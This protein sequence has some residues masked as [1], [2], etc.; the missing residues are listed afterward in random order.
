MLINIILK[1]FRFELNLVD[2]LF[3]YDKFPGLQAILQDM[4]NLNFR[5]ISFAPN[6]ISGRIGGF[7]PDFEVIFFQDKVW[8][9][10]D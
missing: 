8:N 7:Y 2:Y 9:Y 6:L 4:H 3:R 5:L 10:L 1:F